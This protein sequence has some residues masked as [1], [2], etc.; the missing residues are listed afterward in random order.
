MAVHRMKEEGRHGIETLYF[1][2]TFFGEQTTAQ[3]QRSLIYRS[4]FKVFKPRL[5]IGSIVFIPFLD[6]G[7]E[8]LQKFWDNLFLIF[9]FF[10][11]LALS[12]Y[13][14]AAFTAS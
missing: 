13:D 7:I 2:F 12:K 8:F 4:W 9:N 14:A 3:H 1:C 5:L 10:D 11:Y 6:K